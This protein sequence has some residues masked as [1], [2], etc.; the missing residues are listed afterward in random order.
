MLVIV[1]LKDESLLHPSF[2]FDKT[3][4]CR[5]P[6]MFNTL[7][8]FIMQDLQMTTRTMLEPLNDYP[9]LS[10]QT[11]NNNDDENDE[12]PNNQLYMTTDNPTNVIAISATV[13]R[14][15]RC[16]V[17]TKPGLMMR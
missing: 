16:R 8:L 15:S 6:Q 7:V 10:E 2:A 13:L 9:P 1:N 17:R 3:Q 11:H 14:C 12:E 5:W 4:R